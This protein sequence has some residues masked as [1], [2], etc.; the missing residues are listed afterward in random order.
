MKLYIR[1]RM[2][3]CQQLRK[4]SITSYLL[5]TRCHLLVFSKSRRLTE[6]FILTTVTIK[7]AVIV[8]LTFLIGCKIVHLNNFYAT[9]QISNKRLHEAL[10]AF[11]Q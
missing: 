3:I 1:S 9:D 2:N 11:F 5:R 4:Q 10:Y 7:K 6:R 8:I